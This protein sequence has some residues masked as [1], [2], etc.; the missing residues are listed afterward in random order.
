MYQLFMGNYQPAPKNFNQYV[1]A[2]ENANIINGWWRRNLIYLDEANF[3]GIT[4][5]AL[6]AAHQA[7]LADQSMGVSADSAGKEQSLKH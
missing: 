3:F 7:I 2:R 1:T 5:E 6:P 4:T